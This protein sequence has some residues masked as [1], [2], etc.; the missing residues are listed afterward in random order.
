[1]ITRL[2]F[3]EKTQIQSILFDK[4][5][6]TVDRAKEWLKDHGYKYG[7]VDT[8]DKYHRFRQLDPKQF[9][10]NI[11]TS[12]GKDSGKGQKALAT[13]GIKFLFGY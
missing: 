3:N 7:K 1:M 4:D 6:W 2:I 11:R 9:D 8:T 13:K 12:G 10:G 5:K